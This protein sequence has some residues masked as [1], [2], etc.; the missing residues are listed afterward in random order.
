MLTYI[1]ASN[2]SIKKTKEICTQHLNS[3]ILETDYYNLV[4]NYATQNPNSYKM[5]WEDDVWLSN[6][7][8]FSLTIEPTGNQYDRLTQ[9]EKNLAKLHPV[10]AYKI[11]QNATTAITE[12][13]NIYPNTPLLNDKGDAFRHAFWM[14]MNERDCGE[15][16]MGNS[17]AYLFGVAHESEDPAALSLEKTMDLFNNSI[18]ISIGSS[19][20]V[21]IFVSDNTVSIDVLTKLLNGELRYLKPLDFSA[22]HL[23]DALPHDGI[24]DCPTCL[25][26]I[27]STTVSTPTNQ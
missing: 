13:Q 26:G 20:T 2:F 4:N 7:Y 16:G 15:D 14:A 25:D 11:G 18:G 8:N 3:L 1:E 24:Q 10:E 6:P 17:I 21:P 22:S 23:Y 12:S 27:I 9:A 5:W 19:Y